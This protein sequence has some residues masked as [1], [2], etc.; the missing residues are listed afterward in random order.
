MF[1]IHPATL[2]ATGCSD[3]KVTIP[4]HPPI[5][6]QRVLRIVFY[7]KGFSSISRFAYRLAEL[8]AFK[9]RV[10][11]LVSK[12]NLAQLQAESVLLLNPRVLNTILRFHRN[13][14]EHFYANHHLEIIS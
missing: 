14:T 3:C 9:S 10:C 5:P 12:L 8:R 13:E 4:L 2:L 1:Y 11:Y 7:G 6:R